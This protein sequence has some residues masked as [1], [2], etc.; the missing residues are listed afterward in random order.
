MIYSVI[1][2]I[3]KLTN[4]II[5]VVFLFAFSNVVAEE[6]STNYSIKGYITDKSTGESLIGATIMIEEL[7]TGVVTNV[8]GFYS[9]SI[10]EGSYTVKI[11]YVGYNT[12]VIQINLTENKELHKSLERLSQDISGVTIEAER[13]DRNISDVRM[14]S[15]VLSVEAI[16]ALPSFMGEVDVLKTL[17]LLPGVS[18]AGEGSTGLTVRGGS[19][20]Q[21]LVLLDEANVYNASHLMGF[22]SVFNADAIKDVQI[23]KGGIPANYGGRLS[24]VID[25]RM[26]D[27]N[28]KEYKASGGIGSISSR[29]T[30]EGPIQ[31][32]VSSFLLSGRRT[33]ADLFL[34]L[35]QDTN[36]R[37]NKLYFYDLN[38]KLNYR[39]DNNNRLFFSGYFGRDILSLGDEFKIGW[40]NATT[41]L[42]W[43]H[44][45][46]SRIFS[47]FSLIYSNFDYLMGVYSDFFDFDWTSDIQ[48]FNLKADFTWFANTRNTVKY[49]V[50][51]AYHMFNPGLVEGI[52]N[53]NSEQK[54]Q[55]PTSNAME[56]AA[57]ILN[58]HE[59]TEKLFIEYGLRYSVFQNIGPAT[60]YKYDESFEVADSTSYG[61]GDFYNTYH[62]PEPRLGVRYMINSNQSVKASYNRMIQYLHQTLFTEMTTPMDIW[63]PSSPNIK[64]QIANQV[65]AGY[66]R[67]FFDHTLHFSVEAYYKTVNN[68]IDFIEQAEVILNRYME[69]E[70]RTGEAYSYGLEF[71]LKRTSGNIS[72]WAS[73]TL[74]RSYREI[75][76]I[77]DG[78]RYVSDYDRP[79]DISI[80]LNYKISPRISVGANWVYHTGKPVTLPIHRYEYMGQV[81]PVFGEKNSTRMPDYH[82]LDLSA[83]LFTNVNSDRRWEGS[84]N[85]SIFNVY[86]RKNPYSYFFRQNEDNP[87]KQDPYK[88]YLFGIVPAVTYNFSF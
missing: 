12:E 43:N 29:L 7:S 81:V 11:S 74:S 21:N 45:F 35:S 40:G 32:D 65:A 33:Y 67:D 76:G 57:Y 23:Y 73:Y 37:G 14:S 42:R 58:E 18:S 66:F 1:K 46:N 20:D 25:I 39:I 68:Q 55:M 72:G 64:P 19:V 84:W 34:Y 10:P 16:R 48:A 83:T 41:T 54:I 13:S 15:N 71:L 79:H 70:V 62:G 49:G 80:A 63:F 9:I 26:K 61:S 56:S 86:N 50:H 69:G 27:G 75:P 53:E 59:I 24:S 2:K 87:Y 44:I 78:N 82:R 88:V 28:Y 17:S 47:N 51:A 30:V 85:F 3:C 4:I 5:A 8:Y 22:F 38:T 31:E 77:N 52:G 6:Y 60:V 36:L